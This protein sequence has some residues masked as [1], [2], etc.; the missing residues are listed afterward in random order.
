MA[1]DDS[2]A[3]GPAHAVRRH[4]EASQPVV[5]VVCGTETGEAP[6]WPGAT[7]E[8]IGNI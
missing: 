3:H 5:Q 7:T 8:N 6:G 1:A 4:G 2:A